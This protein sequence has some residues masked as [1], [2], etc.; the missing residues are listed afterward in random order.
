M[1]AERHVTKCKDFF[2][3]A[4]YGA[5]FRKHDRCY[6][7][8]FPGAGAKLAVTDRP[9][10]CTIY[11]SGIEDNS[12]VMTQNTGEQTLFVVFGASVSDNFDT[13]A[14]CL[15]KSC[16]I[17]HS[18]NHLSLYLFISSCCSIWAPFLLVVIFLLAK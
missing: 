15:L 16:K 4:I 18:Q 5:V 14:D 10:I 2:A 17:F 13:F 11:F 7:Q 1:D 3:H 12:A 8:G 6:F 9:V